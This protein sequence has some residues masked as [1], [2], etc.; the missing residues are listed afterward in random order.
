MAVITQYVV[1]HKGVDKLVTTDKKEADKYDKM[2]E[3]ADNLNAYICGK[4][5]DLSEELAEELTILLSKNK[6][7]VLKIFK[8]AEAG[9]M[10]AQ[11]KADIVDIKQA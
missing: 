6:E 3:V 10:L 8:G 11:E 5:V 1:K 9:E 2:L 4:G 7:S